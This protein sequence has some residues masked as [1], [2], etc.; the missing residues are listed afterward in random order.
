MIGS[1][2]PVL[3]FRGYKNAALCGRTVMGK[4]VE[5]RLNLRRISGGPGQDFPDPGHDVLRAGQGDGVPQGLM[6]LGG[7]D[8]LALRAVCRPAFRQAHEPFR[9]CLRDIADAAVQRI[10]LVVEGEGIDRAG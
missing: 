10:V 8:G 6:A 3:I 5:M 4:C 7:A 1:S 9:L 2:F